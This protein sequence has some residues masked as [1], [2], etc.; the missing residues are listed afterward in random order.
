MF[1]DAKPVPGANSG[2]PVAVVT[3]ETP[4]YV[5]AGGQVADRGSLV[6]QQPEAW[7]IRVEGTFEPVEGLVLHIGT[8]V[9]GEPR[10]GDETR[11]SIDADRRWDIMRNHTATHLL[12]AALRETLGEHARQA[13]SLVAP[14]RL[15]FDFTHPEAVSEAQLRA[16]EDFVNQAVLGDLPVVADHK[17][18]DEAIESGAIALFGEAYDDTVR[19]IRIGD[20]STLSFELCGGTHVPAT[21]VI[22]PFLVVSEGS[23]GAGLRRI[24]AI[25][26][27]RALRLIQRRLDTV[28]RLSEELGTPE[29]TLSD[30]VHELLKQQDAYAKE[31]LKLRQSIA[32]QEYETIESEQVAGVPLFVGQITEADAETLRSL[33][34]RFRSEHP[35]G[36]LVLGSIAEGRPALLAAVTQDLVARGL[37]AGEM[38]R[39][40]AKTIGGGGGGK[41]T[42]A[43]AGGKEPGKLSAALDQAAPWVRS[44][45]K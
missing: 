31:I 15:R 44:R 45:L 18:L 5:E 21:G 26:G 24:E 33:A 23:V 42:L 17:P 13:G 43:Q 8:V 29:E 37:H 25:T 30:R 40:I 10:V 4:F 14:D 36:V 28:R 16:I 6:S 12:H 7:E 39:D 20:N 11:A 22:G 38:I 35:T 34:D 41:P 19:T 2:D 9:A 27:R 3:P 32:L 1:K